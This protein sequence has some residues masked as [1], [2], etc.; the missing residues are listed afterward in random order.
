[1]PYTVE[2]FERD[3]KEEILSKLPPEERQ[4]L[5]GLSLRRIVDKVWLKKLLR[6]ELTTE[7]LHAIRAT[8]DW[9]K[10]ISVED[11]LEALPPEKLLEGHSP[12]EH[13]KGL[14]PD[15]FLRGLLMKE[16]LKR[17]PTEEILKLFPREAIEAYLKKH[18]QSN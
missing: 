12:E 15:K 14:P 7:E 13:L 17:L 6:G 4:R 2:D 11:I 18:P 3:Y 10:Q 8:K 16:R 1:M 5:E 9:V